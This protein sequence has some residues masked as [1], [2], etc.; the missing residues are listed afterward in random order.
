[1]PDVEPLIFRRMTV[2]RLTEIP[3]LALSKPAM[4]QFLSRRGHDRLERAVSRRSRDRNR[5]AG[6]DPQPTFGESGFAVSEAAAWVAAR[7]SPDVEVSNARQSL[8]GL[9]HLGV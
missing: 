8:G 1:M 4:G 2:S 5:T 3:R 6:V 7:L 9:G